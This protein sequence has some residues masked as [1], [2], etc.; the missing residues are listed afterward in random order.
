M[1][2]FGCLADPSLLT[3]LGWPI[4]AGHV[5]SPRS[6]SESKSRSLQDM[7]GA[8]SEHSHSGD[9]YKQGCCMDE[10]PRYETRPGVP[11][12]AIGH[13]QLYTRL[14]RDCTIWFLFLIYHS[15]NAWTLHANCTTWFRLVQQEM[16]REA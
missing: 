2:W 1:E 7:L 16:E 4:K 10:D 9:V 6:F 11:G 13:C 12:V 15:L 14:P 5:H 3:F 8:T